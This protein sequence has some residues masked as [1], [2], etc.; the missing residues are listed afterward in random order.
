MTGR[1][2]LKRNQNDRAGGTTGVRPPAKFAGWVDIGLKV[3]G[4]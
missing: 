2:Y 1:S 3:K 4:K